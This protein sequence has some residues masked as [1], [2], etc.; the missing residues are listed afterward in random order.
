MQDLAAVGTGWFPEPVESTDTRDAR[1]GSCNRLLDGE[2]CPGGPITVLIPCYNHAD[3]VAEAIASVVAQDHPGVRLH[4]VDDG[5]TDGSAEVIRAALDRVSTVECRFDRQSNRG[6]ARTLN[7]MVD[8]VETDLV[9]ILNSDDRYAPNRLS[10]ILALR[11]SGAPFFAFSGGR[12]FNSEDAAEAESFSRDQAR[13][14]AACAGFPT[15]GFGLLA[16]HLP[17]SSSNFVFSRDVFDRAG[18]FHPESVFAED[19]GFVMRC[20]PHVEPVFVADIL[21]GYRLHRANSWK[22]LQHL[23]T[24][25]LQ[26]DWRRYA[27]AAEK[28][29][30]NPVAPVPWRWRRYF[31]L[32]ARMVNRSIDEQPLATLIPGDWISRTEWSNRFSGDVIPADIEQEAM[33]SLLESC[34]RSRQAGEVDAPDLAVLRHRC[35]EYWTALRARLEVV[36]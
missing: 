2:G 33:A 22:S 26:D 20:L 14:F 29:G 30:A 36:R 5:S 32:F 34:Q 24:Q 25:A 35:S 21:W 4:V 7:S 17:V 3:Y 15:V 28:G 13:M 11:N 27:A 18:G 9:A 8:R 1:G 10:R 23:R 31:R 19:R 12:V 6:V 16:C